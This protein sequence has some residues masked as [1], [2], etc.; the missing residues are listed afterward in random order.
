LGLGFFCFFALRTFHL[1]EQ[2]FFSFIFKPIYD[3]NNFPQQKGLENRLY[4][5]L[6]TLSTDI[7]RL[8]E[9]K[10]HVILILEV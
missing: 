5:E 1:L 3:P 9:E 4:T 8:K 2:K 10:R 7:Y 6:S